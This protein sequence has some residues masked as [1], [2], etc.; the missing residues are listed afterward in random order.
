MKKGLTGK[1]NL[2]AGEFYFLVLVLSHSKCKGGFRI[3]IQ[4]PNEV[5][6]HA[7]LLF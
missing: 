6:K 2:I 3:D 1:L 5:D 7:H 4:E